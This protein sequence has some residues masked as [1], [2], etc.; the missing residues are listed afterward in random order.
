[1]T[2]GVYVLNE[3]LFEKIESCFKQVSFTDF[4]KVSMLNHENENEFS[5]LF[6]DVEDCEIEISGLLFSSNEVT[7]KNNL[8]VISSSHPIM[9][10]LNFLNDNIISKEN[11]LTIPLNRLGEFSASPCPFYIQL[12]NLKYLK[13]INK[14]E[15]NIQETVLSFKKKGLEYFYVDTNDYFSIVGPLLNKSFSIENFKIDPALE[16]HEFLDIIFETAK[17]LGISQRTIDSFNE[18]SKKF[19]G[20]LYQDGELKNIL[21]KFQKSRGTYLCS[22]SH[23]CALVGLEIM[24]EFSWAD[25]K[26]KEK[27]VMASLLHDLGYTNQNACL[28]EDVS[29]EQYNK[30]PRAI[31]EDI[32][33]HVIGTL[34]LILKS[35]VIPEDVVMMIKQHHAF[36]S[37]TSV[38]ISKNQVTKSSALF[39]LA[40]SFTS[41]FIKFSLN[42][43]KMAKFFD[44]HLT[45]FS[46]DSFKQVTPIFE[47]KIAQMLI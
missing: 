3:K 12:N 30:L 1:M 17:D 5:L 22:H 10:I 40:H 35:K 13:V 38:K 39:I 18:I 23:L 6:T 29:E 2:I 26:E 47:K 32:E 15:Q 45:R 19:E 9:G 11:Y 27:F 33:S 36:E 28:F 37:F 21:S 14:G 42:K 4:K 46:G 16:S 7:Q 43:S 8:K 24:K 44:E 31:R 34:N 41:K 25:S 20:L